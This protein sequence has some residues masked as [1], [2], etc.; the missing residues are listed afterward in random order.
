VSERNLSSRESLATTLSGKNYRLEKATARGVAV[1]YLATG[2]GPKNVILL[3]GWGTNPWC[4][5]HVLEQAPEE[6]SICAVDFFGE[7]GHPWGGYNLSGFA[8]EVRDLMDELGMDRASVGGHAY[9][10]MTAQLFAARY[11]DRLDKLI[12]IGTGPTTKGHPKLQSMFERLT[13]AEDHRQT[14]EELVGG[15]YET[16]PPQD[17][18]QLYIDHAML[19][20]W[21]GLIEAMGEGMKYDFIPVLP[22]ITVPTLIV[23][24][25]RDT[26]RLY[27]NAEALHTG[28][29]NS[30]L[31]R[32]DC[33][34]YPHEELPEQFSDIVFSFLSDVD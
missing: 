19:A 11:L 2:S 18:F 31:I 25:D 30:Q 4:F 15:G 13:G 10:G 29:S 33:G 22:S 26:G 9:G 23:H 21:D 7:S 3:H 27:A 1:S 32:M 28:I 20:P 8:D 14:L 24:G 17:V 5:R 16:L 6:Y 34:H 12:L